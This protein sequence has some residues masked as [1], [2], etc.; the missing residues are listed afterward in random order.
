M[1]CR[2]IQ[3]YW[4]M[5]GLPKILNRPV[6]THPDMRDDAGIKVLFG[7]PRRDVR[8]KTGGDVCSK[9]FDT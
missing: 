7:G 1:S 3:L 5:R 8:K 9:Y 4:R 6:Y 2:R